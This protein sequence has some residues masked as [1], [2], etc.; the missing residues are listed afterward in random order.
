MQVRL[1]SVN[2]DKSNEECLDGDFCPLN[3][4]LDEGSELG[5]F[6]A[7]ASAATPRSRR[8]RATHSIVYCF[9]DTVH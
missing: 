6:G 1:G 4:V 8:R 3:D 2:I 7:A 9:D 5:M